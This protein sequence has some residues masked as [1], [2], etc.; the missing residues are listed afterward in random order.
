[1][2]KPERYF[3]GPNV[4][5]KLQQLFDSTPGLT[6]GGGETIPTRLQNMQ[7]PGGSGGGAGVVEAYFTGGWVKGATK[8]IV[9]LSNTATT[10]SAINLIRSVPINAGGQTSRICTVTLRTVAGAAANSYVLLNTE[11]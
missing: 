3:I 2:P 4:R 9:F 5:T 10:A 6:G 1:M 11:C 8:Q 7:R